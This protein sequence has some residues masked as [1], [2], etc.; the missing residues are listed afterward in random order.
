MTV[1]I[2]QAPSETGLPTSGS[3]AVID[4]IDSVSLIINDRGH[5]QEVRLLGVEPVEKN[6]DAKRYLLQ[7]L[8]GELVT[9]RF[10]PQQPSLSDDSKWIAYV[11]RVKNGSLLN[12]ELVSQGFVTNTGTSP[13]QPAWSLT[14][15]RASANDLRTSS[16]A[17][18]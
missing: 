3:F 7:T 11:Y 16:T 5:P 4:V 9:L 10:G 18:N 2:V 14:Q 15:R 12:N 17:K 8:R 13:Q 6:R 1:P